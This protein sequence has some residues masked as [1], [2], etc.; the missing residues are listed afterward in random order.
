MRTVA[1][2]G[3]AGFVGSTLVEH[4]LARGDWN[5]RPC[6]HSSGGAWRLAPLGLELHAVDVTNREAVREVLRG[7][8]HV[9]NAARGERD[10]MISGLGNLLRESRAAGVARFVHL[11][12]VSAYGIREPGTF[13]RSADPPTGSLT[14]Y[15]QTKLEQDRMVEGAHRSGLPCVA[16]APPYI[17]GAYSGFL[18]QVLGALRIGSLALVDCGG[19]P[20]SLIDVQNLAIALERALVCERAEGRRLLVT[21]DDTRTWRDLVDALAP[22]SDGAPDPPTLSREEATRLAS[23]PTPP[24]SLGATLRTIG[25]ILTGPATRRA[26]AGDPL[27]GRA[28]AVASTALPEWVKRRIPGRRPPAAPEAR[29]E[30]SSRH[31]RHLLEVQL[32]AIR[33]DCSDA[34]KALD[35]RPALDFDRSIEAFAAW[36]RVTH[37]FGTE[38][39]AALQQL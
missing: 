19:L 4:L 10:V 32:R 17:S 34:K 9:V 2:F 16:L 27:I 5:V 15:G 37:G 26:L 38:S 11:S 31:E 24:A 30:P 28:Y 13:L 33:H 12:S 23:Q 18:L 3:A 39:W 35:Y 1:I 7:C 29:A 6:I 22:L 20:C 36:Y 21:D 14:G 25:S 8:T